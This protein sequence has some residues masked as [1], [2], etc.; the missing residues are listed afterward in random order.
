M[1]FC[2]LVK[3]GTKSKRKIDKETLWGPSLHDSMRD[4]KK[5]WKVTLAPWQDYA[6][7]ARWLDCDV[8]TVKNQICFLLCETGQSAT[9]IQRILLEFWCSPI[10]CI[11]R[12]AW[13]N[14]LPQCYSLVVVEMGTLLLLMHRK[15]L[16]YSM[17][18]VACSIIS[19]LV[20]FVA[21]RI[22]FDAR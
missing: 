17:S 9:Y 7:D 21:L 2:T 18:K 5:K 12:W 22:E 11:Q 14:R 10:Y 4:Q 15:W 1:A 6:L 19:S 8:S 13:E 3:T 20:F 16:G